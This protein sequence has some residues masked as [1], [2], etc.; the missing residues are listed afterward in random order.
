MSGF[1]YSGQWT[2]QTNENPSVKIVLD[3][4]HSANG[5]AGFAYHFSLTPQMPSTVVE[6]FLNS[7]RR[8]FAFSARPFPFDSQSGRIFFGN[9]AAIRYP[10]VTFPSRIDVNF[11]RVGRHEVNIQWKSDIG[12][13]GQCELARTVMPP[14]SLLEADTD[15]WSWNTFKE[16]ATS[17]KFRNFI[18]RG[19]SRDYPLQTAFHRTRRKSLQ[20]FLNNDVRE[21]HRAITGISNYIFD[22]NKPDDLGAFLSLAQHHGYPTPLLDWTY[23]PFVAAWFAY[24]GILKD[25]KHLQRHGEKVRIYSL[26]RMLMSKFTQFQ[27]ITNIVPH[28]SILETLSIE[29]RRAIPQQGLLMLTNVQDVEQHLF[30]L[31]TPHDVSFLK[32]FDLPVSDVDEALNDLAMMGITRSTMLPGIDS[33]CFDLRQRLFSS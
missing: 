22:L 19:Q 21:L 14:A 5:S 16:M 28:T 31:G 12:E 24:E 9:D 23:S 11:K 7:T 33:I 27:H 32:A 17:L 18:F 25:R 8:E 1:D 26:D 3:L 10:G 20:Y 6:I 4:D 30:D 15:V 2:G 13:I 29:N